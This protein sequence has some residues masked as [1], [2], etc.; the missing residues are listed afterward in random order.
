MKV[1]LLALFLLV[2][3]GSAEAAPHKGWYEHADMIAEVSDLTGVPAADLA[4]IAAIESSFNT[5]SKARTSSARGLF[6]FTNRTWRVTLKS[7]GEQYG[8][9]ENSSR[10]DARANALMGA[11]YL[12]ENRRILE[13]RLGREVDLVDVYMAHFISPRRAA[14]VIR[15]APHQDIS[16][17]YPKLAKANKSIFFKDGKGR[18]VKQFRDLI[19]RKVVKS[20]IMY[21][22]PAEEVVALREQRIMKAWWDGMTDALTK[23]WEC[24]ARLAVRTWGGNIK[25]KVNLELNKISF[26]AELLT[27][28][29]Q[30]IGSGNDIPNNPTYVN[31]GTFYVDRRW[32]L[33]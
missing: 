11:E 14:S 4:A 6:Q 21:Q 17:L 2:Y 28:T 16:V 3:A 10:Y 20:Y 9:D 15:A 12:K 32:A 27:D 29:M 30:L 23:P 1:L 18:T 13:K 5:K 31:K 25:A 8:L 22:Q 24:D 7:Y 33:V 19:T 26:S